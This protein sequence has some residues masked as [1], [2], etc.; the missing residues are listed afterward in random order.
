VRVSDGRTTYHDVDIRQFRQEEGFRHGARQASGTALDDIWVPVQWNGFHIA[1]VQMC[2]SEVQLNAVRLQRLE[3]DN[4]LRRS[5]CQSFDLRA[6]R[7]KFGRLYKDKA[8]GLDMLEAFSG[9]DFHDVA[10][11]AAAQGPTATRL[12]SRSSCHVV[13]VVPREGF[14]DWKSTRLNSRHVK[15]MYVVLF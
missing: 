11:R 4:G 15:N 6:S 10:R 8:D 2:F 12:N 14:K 1:D 9:Y 7:E 3:Q 5:R 13:K